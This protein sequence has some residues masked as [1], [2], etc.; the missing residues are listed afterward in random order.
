V[1]GVGYWVRVLSP[2]AQRD[3]RSGVITDVEVVLFD[4]AGTEVHLPRPSGWSRADLLVRELEGD[5]L[6]PDDP[7]ARGVRYL[8]KRDG[9]DRLE[10][11]T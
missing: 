8:M 1:N 4:K 11:T 10:L 9:Q 3:F 5:D 2:Y 6:D 7:I